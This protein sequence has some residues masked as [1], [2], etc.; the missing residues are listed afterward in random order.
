[1]ALCCLLELTHS[2]EAIASMSP[3]FRS[4]SQLNRNLKAWA[5]ITGLCLT[6]KEHYLE[7]KFP[8]VNPRKQ[9]FLE[10]RKIKEKKWITLPG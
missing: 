7:G 9:L 1:M 8:D 6:L 4:E 5:E 10:L 3:G 2:R